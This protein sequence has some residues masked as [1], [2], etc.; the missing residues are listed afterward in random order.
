MLLVLGISVVS[1]GNCLF[2]SCACEVFT[3]RVTGRLKI[4]LISSVISGDSRTSCNLPNYYQNKL[5]FLMR[6]MEI[7]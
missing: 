4:I 7:T 2:L 6:A 3:L 1:H 5:K